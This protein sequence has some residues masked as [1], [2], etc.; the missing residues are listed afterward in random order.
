MAVWLRHCA[1]PQRW[2]VRRIEYQETNFQPT[3]VHRR[4]VFLFHSLNRAGGKV[5]MTKTNDYTANNADDTT[6]PR[7]FMIWELAVVYRELGLATPVAEKAA[8]ADLRMLH[9]QSFDPRCQAA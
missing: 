9:A 2:T 8:I 6:E 1:W 3:A 5:N 4:W 7:T